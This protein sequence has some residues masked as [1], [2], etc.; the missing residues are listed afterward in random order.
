MTNHTYQSALTL[1]WGLGHWVELRSETARSGRV[2]RTAV[3]HRDHLAIEFSDDEVDADGR[4]TPGLRDELVEGRFLT[5]SASDAAEPPLSRWERLG[6][7]VRT[8][9]LSVDNA[10]RFVHGIY[11][12]VARHAFR[13]AA[14]VLQ[15]LLATAGAIAAVAALTSQPTDFGVEAHA[16]PIF[17]LLGGI[18]VAVHELAHAVVVTHFGRTIDRFGFCF[19]LATPT[20]YVE[21]VDALLLSRRQRIIQAAAGP[22][23]EWLVTSIAALALLTLPGD[24]GFGPVLH[25]FVALNAINVVSNLLPFVGLDGSLLLADGI[26]VPDLPRRA[27]G[28]GGRLLAKLAARERPTTE[29]YG[30]LAYAAANAV[31]AIGLVVLSTWLWIEMFADL[32]SMLYRSGPA[33]WLLLTFVGALVTRPALGVLVPRIREAIATSSRLAH[34]LRFRRSVA[35]R[36]AATRELRRLDG[37]VAVLSAG[38]LGLLAGLLQP[39]RPPHDLDPNAWAVVTVGPDHGLTR[40]V[41]A[42]VR[43]DDIHRVRTLEAL[44]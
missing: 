28:A 18:A 2:L 8:L 24:D 25:R 13:P 32:I 5:A 38:Q 31:V 6:R 22:W 30:L 11:R 44:V 35:W 41:H 19:H 39:L 29:D 20:F 17:F 33:G 34:D 43:R 42:A 27:R 26:R 3:N 1:N 12:A 36:T 7:F 9:D 40:P 15:V 21:S 16:I 14:I 4:P 10:D 23:A 37:E